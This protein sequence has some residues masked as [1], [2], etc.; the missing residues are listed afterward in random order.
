SFLAGRAAEAAHQAGDGFA[1]EPEPP[2]I[3]AAQHQAH[4]IGAAAVPRVRAD[5]DIGIARLDLAKSLGELALREPARDRAREHGPAALELA[6]QTL[7]HRLHDLR[8]AREHEHILYP[9]TRRARHGVEHE[10]RALRN[11][12]HPEPRLVELEPTL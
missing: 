2:L 9:E 6:P 1:R 10:A 8:H 3:G 7:E 4:A 5:I 11:V 12:R